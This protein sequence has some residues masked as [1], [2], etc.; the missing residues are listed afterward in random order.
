MPSPYIPN[1][2]RFKTAK[3]LTFNLHPPV[4]ITPPM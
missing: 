2:S 3:E 1:V 4:S